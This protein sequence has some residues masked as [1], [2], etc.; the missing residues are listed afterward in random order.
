MGQTNSSETLFRHQ[1]T[2][3]GK[4]NP[5]DF[6]KHYDRGRSLLSHI[7]SFFSLF[8]LHFLI[9]LRSSSRFFSVTKSALSSQHPSARLTSAE[10]C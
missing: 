3:P 8:Y 10:E 7:F 5:K 9:L 6:I 1:K 2:T 4:K